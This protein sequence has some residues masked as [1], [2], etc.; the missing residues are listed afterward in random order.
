MN[1]LDTQDKL[2][3][4][5]Q[6]QLMTEMK[7]PTGQAPQFLVLSEITRRQKMRESFALE[8]GKDET[9]VA[10]DAVAAAGMPAQFA[11]DMA[12]T[13]APRTDTN[14]N[15]GAVPQQAMP[16]Q[17]SPAPRTM[18]GGGIV[19]LQ[20]GGPVGGSDISSLMTDPAMMLMA[21]RQGMSVQEY[22]DSLAPEAQAQALARVERNR[23]LA[24]EPTVSGTPLAVNPSSAENQ[25]DTFEAGDAAEADRSGYIQDLLRESSGPEPFDMQTLA[26]LGVQPTAPQF[27]ARSA[28]DLPNRLLSG[29]RGEGASA[30]NDFPRV[31]SALNVPNPTSGQPFASQ[32]FPNTFGIEPSRTV[33]PDSANIIAQMETRSPH[34][35]NALAVAPYANQSFPNTF[36][37]MEQDAT[38]Q[39]GSGGRRAARADNPSTGSIFD[40]PIVPNPGNRSGSTRNDPDP[41]V[42]EPVYPTS[43]GRRDGATPMDLAAAAAQ[44]SAPDGTQPVG[45]DTGTPLDG[46][47][48]P[49]AP[50]RGGGG[51]GGGGGGIASMAAQG[52]GAPSDYEQ[53][54]IKMLGAREKRAEQDKWMALAEAGMALMSSSQPTFGGALGEAG[55]AGLGALRAGTESAEGDRLGLLGAIEQSRLGR[56]QVQLQRQAA[57]ARAASGRGDEGPSL[58]IT[59]G[60]NRLLGQYN[61]DIEGL[62]NV[63][64]GLVPGTTEAQRLAAA[65]RRDELVGLRGG[66]IGVM[67]GVPFPRAGSGGAAEIDY[68]SRTQ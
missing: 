53:E 31:P 47:V 19:S 18:S 8:Q 26:G 6:E 11:G 12:G 5:S 66:L 50:S 57:A 36:A 17:G 63:L 2:K 13:M 21:N 56:E 4:L 40:L 58:A 37:P 29:Q 68:D 45:M 28:P 23:L 41:I 61:T 65:N 20:E 33:A 22:Y 39:A 43:V 30:M 62:D 27:D 34:D 24:L 3:N 67:S 46:V 25:Q 55:Q 60:Q 59:A 14:G 42:T 49:P 16:P 9:T 54:L 15:T 44:E 35:P 7:M 32:S 10:Q 64:N 1:I 38:R 48:M 52:G 51:G